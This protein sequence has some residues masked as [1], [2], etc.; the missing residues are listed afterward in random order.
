MKTAGK[1]YWLSAVPE[2]DD[3]GD[4]IKDMFIDGKTVMGPWALMTER[5]FKSFGTGRMGLG[6]GQEYEKQKDGK[7]LKVEG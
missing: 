5:S 6:Y 7:W 3:F 2:K 1:K 4:T